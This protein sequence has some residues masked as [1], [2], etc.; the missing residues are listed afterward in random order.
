MAALFAHLAIFIWLI[1]HIPEWKLW[2]N[3]VMFVEIPVLIFFRDR[4]C[5]N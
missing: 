4:I 1:V 2:W 3:S 5:H